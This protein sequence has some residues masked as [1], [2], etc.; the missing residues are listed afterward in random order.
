MCGNG[1]AYDAFTHEK[2]EMAI[3][4]RSCG[5]IKIFFNLFLQ[6][7][8]SFVKPKKVLDNWFYVVKQNDREKLLGNVK[9]IENSLSYSVGHQT[10]YYNKTLDEILQKLK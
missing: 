3:D 7:L 1:C 2:D 8:L 10:D 4:S 9:V 6:D 5:Y